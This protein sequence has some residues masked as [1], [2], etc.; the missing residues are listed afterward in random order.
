MQYSELEISGSAQ[1]ESPLTEPDEQEEENAYGDQDHNGEDAQAGP[2]NINVPST[3]RGNRP[4]L[5]NARSFLQSPV[6]EKRRRLEEL[7]DARL[8]KE[9]R[10]RFG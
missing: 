7:A 4:I 10:R 5:D 2:S 3:P 9:K 8:E 6:S 1:A